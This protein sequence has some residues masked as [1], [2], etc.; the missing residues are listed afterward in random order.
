MTAT[1]EQISTLER[2]SKDV[3]ETYFELRDLL[4]EL[5]STP[6]ESQTSQASHHSG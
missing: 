1:P 5:R 3:Q 6:S 2:I 4:Q